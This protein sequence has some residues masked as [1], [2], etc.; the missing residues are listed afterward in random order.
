MARTANGAASLYYEIAGDG[1]TVAFVGEIGYGAWQWGWQHAA[2]AGPRES[3]VADVRGAGRSDAPPGPYAIEELAA[4]VEA[5]LADRGARTAHLVGAGLGGAVALTVA[6]RTG[7]IGSLT[8]IGTSARG[9]DLDAE[10][11][12]APPDDREALRASLE[13]ALSAAFREAR[14][15]TLDRI[16]EWRAAED[17]DAAAWEAQAAALAEFNLSDALYEVTVP[18]LVVHGTADAVCPVESGQALAEGLPRGEFAPVEGAGHLAHVEASKTVND[19][20]LAFFD[21]VRA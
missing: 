3:L 18:A 16:V 13:P 11:L 8:L 1:E 9:A 2:V 7:R 12:Y 6:R 17:A 14:P 5:V 20:L 19:R 4:D 10:R 21:G 15:E